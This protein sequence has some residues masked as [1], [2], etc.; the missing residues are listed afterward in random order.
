M[1]LKAK[2]SKIFFWCF[3]ILIC[4]P[5]LLFTIFMLPAFISMPDEILEF[6]LEFF[7]DSIFYVLL[8][9]LPITANLIMAQIIKHYAKRG[10]LFVLPAFS[11]LFS[12]ACSIVYFAFTGTGGL[13]FGALP[14]VILMALIH[15]LT[16][17][18]IAVIFFLIPKEKA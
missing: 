6:Y 4:L 3:L 13:M 12:I 8:I 2:L 9:A 15:I 14:L 17:L 16:G 5:L 11:F 10:W 1:M 7:S 18:I